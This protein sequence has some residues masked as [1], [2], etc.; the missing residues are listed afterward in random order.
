MMLLTRR[1]SKARSSRLALS[2]AFSKQASSSSAASA[3]HLDIGMSSQPHPRKT[4]GGEDAGFFAQTPQSTAF[5]V[6]DGVSAACD[7][8]L[9]AR[10]LADSAAELSTS[11]S[12]PH[13]LLAAAWK[14]VSALDGRSTA[15]FGTID[16]IIDGG[17]PRLRVSNLG[18]SRCWVLRAR[19]PSA[20]LGIAASTTPQL[21]E[22][23]CP[24]QIG[25]LA[26][27]ELNTPAD[28]STSE[29]DLVPGDVVLVATDGLFDVLHPL[30]CLELVAGSLRTDAPAA[31]IAASLVDTAITLS[32][33]SSRRSPVMIAFER[34]GYVARGR[35]LQDDVT[36]VVA[37]VSSAS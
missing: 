15:C 30:E 9:Y 26:G 3:V 19:G 37:R 17:R 13:D 4:N 32:K 27:V 36:V 11:I 24:Y 23:N 7:D 14:S 25:K 31:A 29:V 16:G 28:A 21:W 18:D 35:E 20:K 6:A 34:E 5:G 8:G 1:L 10:R 12:C 22:F 2:L 33:D